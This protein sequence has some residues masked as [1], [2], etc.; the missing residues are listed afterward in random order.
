MIKAGKVAADLYYQAGDEFTSLTTP[1]SA[2]YVER[3]A[4]VEVKAIEKTDAVINLSA[5]IVNIPK[6]K[7]S[8]LS[9]LEALSNE[10]TINVTVD[11]ADPINKVTLQVN[12]QLIDQDIEAPYQF[13]LPSSNISQGSVTIEVAA[14]TATATGKGTTTLSALK[15]PNETALIVVNLTNNDTLTATLD[16]FL[17]PVL[18]LSD[19]PVV[20]PDDIPAI[21]VVHNSEPLNDK[22]FTR[23][24]DYVNLGGNLYYENSE[25]L[26]NRALTNE[27]WQSFGIQATSLWSQSAATISGVDNSIVAGLSYPTP[28]GYFLFNELAA[29]PNNSEGVNNLWQTDDGN[30][31][32]A[33]TNTI[34]Q[35]KVIASTGRYSWLAASL[36]MSVIGK[37][38]SFFDLDN[39]VRPVSI[40]IEAQ[41]SD[42][43]MENQKEVKFFLARS[44]DNGNNSSVNIVI[45]SENAIEDVDY[46]PLA[47]SNIE[48]SAG[49]LS[50]TIVLTLLDDLK[51]DGDK[52]LYFTISGDDVISEVE[53]ETRA[54]LHIRDDE[55]RGALQF[56]DNSVVVAENAESFNVIIERIGG[57]DDQI[58]FTL[59][60]IDGSAIAGSDYQA[61]HE[62]FVFEQGVGQMSLLI[63]VTDNASYAED[64]NFV[65]E[66][67]SDYLTGVQSTITVTIY[68]DEADPES[69][70]PIVPATPTKEKSSS[71][72][73]SY[74]LLYLLLLISGYRLKNIKISEK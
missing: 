39:S 50:K 2:S 44:Y 72:G 14:F 12:G 20:S 15:L 6:I 22:Q 61:I 41:S 73:T 64:K 57:S 28:E 63:K 19:I 24:V 21:F 10:N 26:F 74:L 52:E 55:N 1:S 67:T 5:G 35:S 66:L 7:L 53:T 45:E 38:L 69:A 40:I 59:Q 51:A 60:S 34:N 37:Y 25:W 29:T 42:W 62:N 18:R 71:G 32:Y 4:S 48:F 3:N 27:Q 30:F 16:N 49:E 23:L 36:N 17:K 33:V 68:N 9:H 13:T 46:A 31:S 65:L 11:S 8:G 70:V 47:S 54:Y 58:E 56:K 43:Y